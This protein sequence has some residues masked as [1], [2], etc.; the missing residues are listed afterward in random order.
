M[1]CIDVS[2][3]RLDENHG[4]FP[5]GA[6]E[7]S[8]LW[9]PSHHIDGIK[10][11]WPYLFKLSNPRYPEQ[12]FCEVVAY[13][14]G[15]ELGIDVPKAV[16]AVRGDGDNHQVGA[17]IEWFYN[18]VDEKFIPAGDYIA[19]I[20]PLFDPKKGERHSLLYMNL[21]L[22]YN[23]IKYPSIWVIDALFFDAVIGNTDRH[24]ENWGVVF[25]RERNADGRNI[26]ESCPLFDNG[27]SLGHEYDAEKAMLFDDGKV[28]KYIEKGRHHI[29]IKPDDKERIKHLYFIRAAISKIGEMKVLY[30]RRIDFLYERID[31]ILESAI[32]LAMPIFI[33]Q[34]RARWMV[35]LI[36][37]RLVAIKARIM[38]IVI[39]KIAEP[40][41][42][43]VTWQPA[44]GGTRYIIG[45]IEGAN[46]DNPYFKYSDDED[47]LSNAAKHGFVGHPSFRLNGKNYPNPLDVF[48]RRLPPRARP[49]F[50]KY[51]AEFGLP[52]TFDGSNACLLAYTGAR[53]PSDGFSILPD[54]DTMDAPFD[55]ITELAGT[56]YQLNVSIDEIQLGDSVDIN[57]E[58]DNACDAS[59][60]AVCHN[61]VRI[62][63]IN[64]AHCS[65]IR[66]LL[67]T[68]KLSSVVCKKSGT[69]E[70]PLIHINLM[71]E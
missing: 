32:Q 12:Y 55:Y 33:S 34:N 18:P 35:R 48:M 63:Y 69:P 60:I 26:V 49:D 15:L 46:T 20:D 66:K 7:K 2:E 13:Q 28:L 24:Q 50:Y 47:E 29:K 9:S 41:R 17:L 54:L 11:N 3:W 16:V 59:A 8:M 56:R 70:R 23:E 38:N 58:D 57:L 30:L 68:K 19:K 40:N 25:K 61:G 31:V 5:V 71:V 43:L 65:S 4:Y 39:S 27:T 44:S 64:K 36:K 53:L 10:P 1:A 22:R 42:L 67:T 14:I 52:A 45:S 51:L 37:M 62:G 6:R 21:I